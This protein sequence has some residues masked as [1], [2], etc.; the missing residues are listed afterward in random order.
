MDVWTRLG[1]WAT[2][3]SYCNVDV[4][5]ITLSTLGGKDGRTKRYDC[6]VVLVIYDVWRDLW[7]ILAT[8]QVR[9]VSFMV[10]QFVTTLSFVEVRKQVDDNV[11]RINKDAMAFTLLRTMVGQVG[12]RELDRVLMW[13]LVF[14]TAYDDTSHA[15]REVATHFA[16]LYGIT[17]ESQAYCGGPCQ[18]KRTTSTSG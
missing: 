16:T 7:L 11:A 1:S 14:F 2:F 15:H 6:N 12:L 10:T 4:I 3:S 8:N 13:K 9:Y 5:T 17:L 18:V